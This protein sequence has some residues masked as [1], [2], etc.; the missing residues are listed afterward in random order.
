MSIHFKEVIVQYRAVCILRSYFPLHN[1]RPAETA[2]CLFPKDCSTVLRIQTPGRG[3]K[4]R[5][6]VLHITKPAGAAPGGKV[7]NFGAIFAF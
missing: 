3:R 7:E 6:I 5:V 4:H 1:G 2:C